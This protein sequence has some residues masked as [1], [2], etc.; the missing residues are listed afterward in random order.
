MAEVA[1]AVLTGPAPH[2]SK[3]NLLTG[4]AAH[5]FA[6]VME[7][8][9]T[10]TGEPVKHTSPPAWFVKLVL[11]MAGSKRHATL[12]V[13]HGAGADGRHQT[14]YAATREHQRASAG[15]AEAADDQGIHRMKPC[16][17]AAS[18]SAPYNII[19][20][21][22]GVA[23]FTKAAST[24]ASLWHRSADWGC[25]KPKDAAL[26]TAALRACEVAPRCA[27]QSHVFRC[28]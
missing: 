28:R 4:D 3:A 23:G 17:V 21:A 6:E 13:K 10:V 19:P 8:L 27:L 12:A 24:F 14:T 2:A 16:G 26:V 18:C 22:P 5:S 15:G 9:R 20:A 25:R 11:P 7:M 1:A